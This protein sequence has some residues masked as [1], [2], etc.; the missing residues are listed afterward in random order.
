MNYDNPDLFWVDGDITGLDKH[1]PDWMLYLYLSAGSKYCNWNSMNGSQRRLLKRL[2]L[3]LQYHMVNKIT[4]QPGNVWRLI[5][6]MMYS[7]GKETSHGDSWI[8]AIIF[9]MYIEYCALRHPF[10]SDAIRLCLMQE[11][12]RIIVYGDDHI[13]CCPKHLRNVINANGFAAF[14]KEFFDMELR[15]F[16]EYDHFVSR[17]DRVTGNFIYRG[18]KFLKRYFIDSYLPFAA[19]ILPFKPV[20]E[21]AVRLCAVTDDEDVCALVLKSIGQAWDS[22]GT[23]RVTYDVCREAY[24][25]AMERMTLTPKELYNLWKNDKTKA[26]FLK[27]LIKKSSISSEEFFE[28]F[29]TIEQL[30]ARHIYVPEF[31]NNKPHIFSM[32]RL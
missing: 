26:R 32:E 1:I 28:S 30:Q 5:I 10:L 3:L 17:V 15:D 14:L 9:F 19:P 31:C 24:N 16:K 2:Y 22:M 12:I 25:F 6:G 29:P 21:S 7:G 8:M 11:F 18:P 23:N 20:I 13:W 27:N 4:L